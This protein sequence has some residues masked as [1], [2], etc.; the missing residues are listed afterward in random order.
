MEHIVHAMGVKNIYF[1]QN[2]YHP[3]LGFK[4]YFFIFNL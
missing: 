4:E 3:Y 2:K 1:D